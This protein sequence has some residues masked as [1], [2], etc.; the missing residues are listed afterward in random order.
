ML[1]RLQEIANQKTP[2]TEVGNESASN[3]KQLTCWNCR[4]VGHWKIDCSKPEKGTED[5]KSGKKKS[6]GKDSDK[7]KSKTKKS[8]RESGRGKHRKGKKKSYRG[9]ARKANDDSSDDSS[10]ESESGSDETANWIGLVQYGDRSLPGDG[11]PTNNGES[12]DTK[13]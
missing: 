7:D 12:P 5:K 13:D 9:S 4:E 2:G 8:D 6:H 10:D 3:V 11:S 1:L